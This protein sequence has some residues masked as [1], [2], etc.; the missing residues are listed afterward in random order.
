MIPEKRIVITHCVDPH[1][2][3]FKY[4]DNCV[5]EEYSK[6]D[7]A[8]QSYGNDLYK[9]QLSAHKPDQNELIIFFDVISNKWLRG[10]VMRAN[11]DE[12]TLWCIDIG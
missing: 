2:F 6:F 3:F 12:I 1:N 9:R 4:V 8:L 5:N 11:N 7:C 10:R